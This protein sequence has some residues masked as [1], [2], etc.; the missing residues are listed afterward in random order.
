M[1]IQ[2]ELQANMLPCKGL[3]KY[4]S[5]AHVPHNMNRCKCKI[6][7]TKD[8]IREVAT[9]DCCVYCCCQSFPWEKK[10]VA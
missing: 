7:L 1:Q 5:L 4:D 3:H 9:K 6:M 2:E 10:K 8:S